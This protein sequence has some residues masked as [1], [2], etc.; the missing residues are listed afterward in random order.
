M[1]EACIIDPCQK[2]I[3]CEYRL[4]VL[5]CISRPVALLYP[6]RIISP[7]TRQLTFILYFIIIYLTH[8]T[9]D[10]RSLSGHKY[11]PT[12]L[13]NPFQ[14]IL[15]RFH[16]S[17]AQHFRDSDTSSTPST[18]CSTNGPSLHSNTTLPLS[19]LSSLCQTPLGMSTPKRPSSAQR[20]TSSMIEPSSL[21]VVTLT[22]P[23]RITKDPSFVGC[24][25][26]GTT[27]PIYL[28]QRVHLLLQKKC[29][30]SFSSSSPLAK[31]ASSVRVF[32]SPHKPC[33]SERGC[34]DFYFILGSGRSRLRGAS[35]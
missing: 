1:S 2:S 7:G 11:E 33:S 30:I 10:P 28:P 19:R 27:I 31:I 4:F 25:W 5:R 20:T 16:S 22:L 15:E 26:M 6:T 14:Y 34:T 24:R 35:C 29:P 8:L 32:G 9:S 13:P 21:R 12:K 3:A 18:S 17:V 23:R